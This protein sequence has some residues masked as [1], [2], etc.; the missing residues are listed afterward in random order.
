M[1]HGGAAR[2]GENGEAG[3]PGCT[4][5]GGHPPTP[6]A[7]GTPRLWG[8]HSQSS[9]GCGSLAGPHV[10]PLPASA[11]SLKTTSPSRAAAQPGGHGTDTQVCKH[12]ASV[13]NSAAAFWGLC[14]KMRICLTIPHC[15]T[16]YSSPQPSCFSL[17]FC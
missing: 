4:P 2:H 9:P 6:G 13:M 10:T 12:E 7:A 8:T 15:I 1:C 17:V 14:N 16:C 3:R 5:R 11:R